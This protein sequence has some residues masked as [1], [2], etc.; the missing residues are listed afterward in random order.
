MKKSKAHSPSPGTSLAMEDT[1]K[2]CEIALFGPILLES[3]RERDIRSR[4]AQNQ[5]RDCYHA[6]NVSPENMRELR[7]LDKTIKMEKSAI[8]FLSPNTKLDS[9]SF[10]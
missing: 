10:I 2:P 4:Y 5:K 7:V 1:H 9:D 8:W 6:N 3:D